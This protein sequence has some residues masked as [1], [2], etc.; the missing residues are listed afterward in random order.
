MT[1]DSGDRREEIDVTNERSD[2]CR[3]GDHGVSDGFDG[4]ST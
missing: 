3:F 2:G 4:D 1:S